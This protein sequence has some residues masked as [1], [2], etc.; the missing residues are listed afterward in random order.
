[1]RTLPLVLL[2]SALATPTLAAQQNFVSNGDFANGT[3]GWTEGGYSCLPGIET[4]DTTGLGASQCYASNP[5]GQVTP[6][7]YAPNWI[8]QPVIIVPG[9]AY[10]FTAEI[11]VD[12]VPILGNADA[13]TVYV[14]VG[15]VEITRTTLGAFTAGLMQRAR[16]CGRFTMTTGGPQVPL[17]INFHRTFL[18]NNDTPR[19]RIDDISLRFAFGPTFC[20]MGNRKLG[21]TRTVD[22]L[23]ATSEPV[24]F[25][26]S[27]NRL[28]NGI[29]VPGV[30]GL[31]FL[32]P[33]RMFFFFT[34]TTSAT[35]RFSFPLPLP[36]DAS[37]LTAVLYVQGLQVSLAAQITLGFDQ[38]LTF[39]R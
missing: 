10:E 16:V 21:Q 18:C 31:W 14:E 3:A 9:V 13:G 39:V 8:E 32:D 25:F 24:V 29:Q 26:F 7:P 19:T 38:F 2:A 30:N 12:R 6:P 35:G 34:G 20:L 5:G 15:G 33:T 22:V 36:N 37:L 23:G 28:M 4:F 1:M 27:N 17:R 11:A